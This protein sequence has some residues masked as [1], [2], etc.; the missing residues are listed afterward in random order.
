MPDASPGFPPVGATLA[1][2]LSAAVS[3]LVGRRMKLLY[4]WTDLG[5]ITRIDLPD[6]HFH[7]AF[8][9]DSGAPAQVDGT[10]QP[11]GTLLACGRA[12]HF[13]LRMPGPG[14]WAA[15]TL[16]PAPSCPVSAILAATERAAPRDVVPF[17]PPP[18]ALAALA[19]LHARLVP[20]GPDEA[21]GTRPH[22]PEA[23][24]L[25]ALQACLTAPA[26]PPL[27]RIRRKALMDRLEAIILTAA[28]GTLTATDLAAAT[29]VAGRTLR[30]CCHAFTGMGPT[31]YVLRRRMALVR[32][33]LA[34]A[35]PDRHNVTGMALAHGFSELGRFAVLYKTLFGESPSVTLKRSGDDAEAEGILALFGAGSRCS[36]PLRTN[37]A[38]T[39]TLPIGPLRSLG[40][41][42]DPSPPG[43]LAPW[44]PT[45]GNAL[46]TRLSPPPAPLA[47]S[48]LRRR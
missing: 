10:M 8:R 16:A 34:R 24:L 21:G 19:G 13:T 45:K 29:G 6:D 3:S 30:A 32:H 48:P 27:S 23:P 35:D 39:G 38:S 20:S 12:S 31:Q 14:G 47:A 44:P 41:L 22:L 11:P 15:I 9:I 18:A 17:T 5:H 28:H 25:A 33:A 26:P 4:G 42:R 37:P 36:V 7:L 46:G 43:G 1:A 40:S 2:S